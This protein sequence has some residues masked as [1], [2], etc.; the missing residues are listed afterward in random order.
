MIRVLIAEDQSLIRGALKTLLSLEADIEV[1]GEAADGQTAVE[2]CVSL[3]PD[4][5]LIDI[6]L[7]LLSGLEVIAAVAAQV[8]A[9]K[10][11]V[12]TTFA[13]PG[14]LQQAMRLG[15]KG[16]MLKESEVDD[17]VAAIHT[18]HQGGTVMD[19]GL[20][21]AAWMT[22]NPLNQRELELLM[23]AKDGLSTRALATKLCLSEGT[24]RNYVS[25]ILS[26]LQVESRQE[27]IRIAEENGWLQPSSGAKGTGGQGRDL[28]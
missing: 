20:M 25:D 7:P 10:C 5:A 6:E 28:P 1:V 15:A 3:Q 9:C 18:I 19:S 24:V 16:Y 21:A 26:K 12:V 11:L 23:A 13:R 22:Q 8:P 2:L 4:V 17:L 27:A 14:Y